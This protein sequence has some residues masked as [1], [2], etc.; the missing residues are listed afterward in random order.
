MAAAEISTYNDGQYSHVRPY[1]KAVDEG[2]PRFKVGYITTPATAD[3]G[4]TIT[5]D[6]Y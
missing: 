6:L 4:D 2:L 5:L 1:L 3:D